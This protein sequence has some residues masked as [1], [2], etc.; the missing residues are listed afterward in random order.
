MNNFFY[1]CWQIN[2]GALG[3]MLIFVAIYLRYNHPLKQ[4]RLIFFC[5]ALS[6]LVICLFSPLS[7]LS[8]RYLFSAHMMVHVILLLCTGPLLVASLQKQ[9]NPEPGIICRL[10]QF[11]SRKPFYAWIAGVGIMWLWHQPSLFN[12]SMMEVHSRSNGVMTIHLLETGSLV[13]AGMLF[14]WPLISP[15]PSSRLSALNGVVYLFT[16]CIGCSV[17]G[18][19]ITFAPTGTY[20][21]FLA[22]SDS[23]QI[24]TLILN[25]W[26]LTQ[27]ADQQMAGLIMWVPCCFLY[28]LYSLLL[29]GRWYKEKDRGQKY[30]LPNY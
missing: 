8:E 29:L 1:A 13:V 11:L 12:H 27:A 28:V 9:M 22:M 23:Y 4:S 19:L 10:S 24:N 20:R 18:L 3:G 26:G 2:Y 14:S 6:L 7:I 5:M 30:I 21:H 17:L 25:R 16:A 15:I